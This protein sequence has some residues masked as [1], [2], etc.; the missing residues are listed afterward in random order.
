M[1]CSSCHFT[2]F[3]V[4]R[5]LP[6]GFRDL[7]AEDYDSGFEDDEDHED[8]DEGEAGAEDARGHSNGYR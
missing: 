8:D 4:E 5:K 2:S 6:P 1:W 3:Q 7:M